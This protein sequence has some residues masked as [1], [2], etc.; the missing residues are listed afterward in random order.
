M[1]IELNKSQRDIHTVAS[2]EAPRGLGLKSH[3]KDYHQKLTYPI[4]ATKGLGFGLALLPN[5]TIRVRGW[6]DDDDEEA[7]L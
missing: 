5:L 6:I 3:P 4:L 1:K 2:R 7:G